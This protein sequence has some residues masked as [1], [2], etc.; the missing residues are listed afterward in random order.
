MRPVICHD[1]LYGDPLHQGAEGVK[2]GHAHLTKETISTYQRNYGTGTTIGDQ[3]KK[4]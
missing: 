4:L 2:D 1:V 3:S